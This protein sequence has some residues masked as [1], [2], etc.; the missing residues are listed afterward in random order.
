MKTLHAHSVYGNGI[1]TG[2]GIE[3]H[4]KSI[5][6]SAFNLHWRCVDAADWKWLHSPTSESD[7]LARMVISTISHHPSSYERRPFT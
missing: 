3:L 2:A 5:Q 7:G 6:H 4:N 1:V